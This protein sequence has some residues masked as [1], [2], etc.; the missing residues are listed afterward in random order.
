MTYYLTDFYFLRNKLAIYFLKH[1]D[2]WKVKD[3]TEH[4]HQCM[5][6]SVLLLE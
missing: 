3:K 4:C 6:Q 5:E 1:L 2:I